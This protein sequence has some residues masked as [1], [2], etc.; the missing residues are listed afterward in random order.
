L[1]FDNPDHSEGEDRF[2]LLGLSGALRILVVVH[3]YR[4]EDEAIRIISAR[5]ATS[6]ERETYANHR[7]WT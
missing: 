3:C 1:L 5:Q 6:R 7:N 2:L 4:E